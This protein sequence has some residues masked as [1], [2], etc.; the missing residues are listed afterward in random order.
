V[1][2]ARNGKVLLVCEEEDRDSL[3]LAYRQ[4]LDWVH[5]ADTL[6]IAR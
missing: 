5:V 3:G 6:T 1:I 2:I 4:N